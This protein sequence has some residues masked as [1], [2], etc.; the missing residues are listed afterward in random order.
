MA[1]QVQWGS[2]VLLLENEE[3]RQAFQE[4]RRYYFEDINASNPSGRSG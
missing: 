4:E 2:I 3:F 1:Q